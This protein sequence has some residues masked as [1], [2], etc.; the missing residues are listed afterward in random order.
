MHRPWSSKELDR[1]NILQMATVSDQINYYRTGLCVVLTLNILFLN[2]HTKEKFCSGS[3]DSG[4]KGDIKQTWARGLTGC[5]VLFE[6]RAEQNRMEW[7][8]QVFVLSPGALGSATP[9]HTESET[10]PWRKRYCNMEWHFENKDRDSLF[11]TYNILEYMLG[12]FD[13]NRTEW[14]LA[15]FSVIYDHG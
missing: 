11:D 12:F 14:I 8:I 7:N 6:K 15:L 1:T 3:L 5:W 10:L 9:A 4:P 13:S 2:F